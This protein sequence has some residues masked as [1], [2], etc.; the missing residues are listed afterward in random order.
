MLTTDGGTSD[1]ACSPNSESQASVSDVPHML[2]TPYFH[3]SWH[4]ITNPTWALCPA[5]LHPST[6]AAASQNTA[7]VPGSSTTEA[8]CA[9]L[10]ASQRTRI[11][12][13]RRAF[14]WKPDRCTTDD[15]SASTAAVMILGTVS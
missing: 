8:L 4:A 2:A 14:G 5:P 6:S 10:V 3:I 15:N 9:N 13:Y 11:G 1:T 12:D 7:P